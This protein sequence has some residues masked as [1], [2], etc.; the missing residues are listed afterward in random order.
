MYSKCK[1]DISNCGGKDLVSEYNNLLEIFNLDTNYNKIDSID[2]ES[3]LR[4]MFNK[5]EIMYKMNTYDQ[6]DQIIQLILKRAFESAI[7][8][9]KENRNA[10]DFIAYSLL[11]NGRLREDQILDILSK[12][13]T[14]CDKTFEKQEKLVHQFLTTNKKA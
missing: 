13:T 3:E 4:N 1:I 11:E 12:T 2:K 10:L 5:L 7:V 9:L 8:H 14:L 6:C